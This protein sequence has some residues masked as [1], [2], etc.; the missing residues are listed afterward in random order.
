MARI[1]SIIARE[2]IDSRG[3]PTVQAIVTC[4][5]GNTGSAMVPSGASTGIHEAVELRDRDEKRYFGKG[6]LQ[7]VEHV[8][9]EIAHA[10]IDMDTGNQ[11]K[12]DHRMIELDGTEQKSRLGANAILA[13]S[14]ACVRAEAQAQ[15]IPLYSMIAQAM[16]NRPMVMPVPQMNLINGGKHASNHLSV[17]EFHVLPVGAKNFATALRM[18]VEIHH[19][20]HDILI[21]AGF[22]TEVGDEGGFAPK[23]H[24]SEDAFGFIVRA[25][26][27]A[28][29][30]PGVDACLG[31]DAA[32]SEFYEPD[33][34]GY[35][36]DGALLQANDLAFLYKQWKERYPLISIE[37]PFA[38]DAWND[39]TKFTASNGMY[40]QIVGDDLYAT[41]PA[42]IQQGIRSKAGNAVLIK[43]NQ[44][45][46]FSETLEAIM[47]AQDAG[48]N[49]IISHRSGETEDTFIADLS[50]A[51]GAGQIKTGA[52]SRSDRTSKYNR[53]LQI[54]DETRAPMGHFMQRFYEHE[55]ARHIHAMRGGVEFTPSRSIA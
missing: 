11:Q 1:K 26:E 19:A 4:D 35:L 28:G 18:G 9:T 48:H 36:I 37:D 7:A 47:H 50:V 25:I 45:G 32:A 12:I 24:G 43:P 16:P 17:Q 15:R 55:S 3:T 10:L 13:V 33:S 54:E 42:R 5:G 29:Y 44:I 6:V 22:Q 34:E 2:V 27:Q 14:L 40:A 31:I 53:L 21:N 30:V 46:T 41:N 8:N 52:P 20:L 23:L 39:W 38:E 49:V 51:V